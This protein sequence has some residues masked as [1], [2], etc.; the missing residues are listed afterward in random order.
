MADGGALLSNVVLFGLLIGAFYLLAIRPQRRR[1]QQ[2]AAVRASLEV[3]ARVLTTAGLHATVA[4]LDEATGT[5][6]LEIAPG[7]VATFAA[8]AVVQVLDAG[9]GGPAAEQP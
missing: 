6:D 1:A 4:G 5:V 8:Q 7:V 2:L 9:T 3:G